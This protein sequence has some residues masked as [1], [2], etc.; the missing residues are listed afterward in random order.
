MSLE[1]CTHH[2]FL[3]PNHFEVKQM[4][5]NSPWSQYQENQ[6]KTAT[7]GKLLLMA[8]DGAIKF[9]GV[10]I[11]KMKEGKL[12]EQGAYIRKTQNLLLELISSLDMSADK[13]LASNLYG[14]YSYLFDRLTHA[15]IRDDVQ[16]LEEAI[17]ILSE[18]RSA[19]EEADRVT[20]SGMGMEARAA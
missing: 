19:W 15:N 8:Y 14:V 12:D 10:A 6:L 11:E 7:P 9:A 4:P 5:V 18:L 2:S 13:Q 1:S 16:A 20:R 17:Q 3:I